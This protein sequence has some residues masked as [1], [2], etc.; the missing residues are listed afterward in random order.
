[1][2]MTKMLRQFDGAAAVPDKADALSGM[3][4]ADSG[5]TGRR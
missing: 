1:M 2:L 5:E 4:A 3:E